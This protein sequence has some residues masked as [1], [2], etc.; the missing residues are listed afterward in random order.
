MS[1]KAR[2]SRNYGT[3]CSTFLMHEGCNCSMIIPT[4]WANLLGRPGVHLLPPALP[5]STPMY[6]A[7]ALYIKPRVYVQYN[8]TTV[9]YVRVCAPCSCTICSWTWWHTLTHANRHRL[10]RTAASTRTTLSATVCMMHDITQLVSTHL[11]RTAH[12][13]FRRMSMGKWNYTYVPI[14]KTF[15]SLTM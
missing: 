4:N 8:V 11:H 7:V 9:Q 13:E 15:L 12:I 1:L 5:L 3:P 6:L 10:R 14:R 2:G